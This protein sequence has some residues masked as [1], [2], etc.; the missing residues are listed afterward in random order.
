MLAHQLH[1]VY[2]GQQR[3]RVWD[4]GTRQPLDPAWFAASPAFKLIYAQ[5]RVRI[6][7]VITAEAGQE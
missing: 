5:D 3:G 1:Y 2:I 7:Q 6:F 4:E